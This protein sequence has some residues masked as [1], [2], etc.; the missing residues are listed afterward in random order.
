MKTYK[1]SSIFPRSPQEDVCGW[2]CNRTIVRWISTIDNRLHYQNIEYNIVYQISKFSLCI[3]LISTNKS[4][5]L[6]NLTKV[7]SGNHCAFSSRRYICRSDTFQGLW[8]AGSNRCAA[9]RPITLCVT[10]C[11]LTVRAPVSAFMSNKTSGFSFFR[12]IMW[13]SSKYVIIT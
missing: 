1:K 10:R 13:I 6:Q 5:F 11:G 2:Q 4:I 12:E 3:L 7:Q 9:S 8:L